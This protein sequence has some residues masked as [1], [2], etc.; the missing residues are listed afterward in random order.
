MSLQ[1]TTISPAQEQLNRTNKFASKMRWKMKQNEKLATAIDNFL[2]EQTGYKLPE[3]SKEYRTKKGSAFSFDPDGPALP[4]QEKAFELEQV[5]FEEFEELIKLRYALLSTRGYFAEFKLEGKKRLVPLTFWYSRNRLDEAWN[6]RKSQIIRNRYFTFL[7]TA[8]DNAGRLL[9]NHYLPMHLTLTLPHQNGL[10]QGKR[11]YAKQLITLFAELRKHEPFKLSVYAGEYGLEIKKSKNH[12]L[13]IHLHC[14]ILQDP[15]IKINDFREWLVSKWKELTG[16]T[17]N[18]SGL[19]YES[20]YTWERDKNGKKVKEP[21]TVFVDGEWKCIP[22]EFVPVKKYI[23]P[24]VSPLKD[25]L[26][27]VME[28]IKYHFKPGCLETEEGEY[29]IALIYDILENTKGKRLYSRF[30]AFYK[31]PELN[32]NNLE[33]KPEEL[34]E[35]ELEEEVKASA[36]GVE[37]RLVNPF[38]LEPAKRHDYDICVGK[39]QMLK[40]HPKDSPFPYEPYIAHGSTVQLHKCDPLPLKEIIRRHA[41]QESRKRIFV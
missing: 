39:P 31:Q 8:K 9:I 24:G 12:G 2:F 13:H 1:K 22:G 20:L 14:L 3:T 17:S 37:E 30:G 41:K 36:D 5:F 32:F 18:F 16:N 35:E 28:C 23:E 15:R 11:F 27:G 4:Q 6:M 26:E 25:Y 10:F 29:D 7:Q 33:K 21:K 38:T 40:Y 19:H 34:T